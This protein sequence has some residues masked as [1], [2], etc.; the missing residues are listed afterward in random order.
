MKAP[1]S[2]IKDYVNLDGLSIEEIAR[3]LTMTGLEVDGILLVGLPKPEGEKHE[4]KYEGLSW[5]PDKFVVAR[6]DEVMPHPN[7]DKLVLCRLND[8]AKEMIILT[9]APNLFPYKAI[10]PLAEPPKVAYAR[11]GAQLY[12]GHQPCLL[13]TS[14]SPRDRG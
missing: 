2:W 4:F 11:E 7:A 9:G 12:D 14:P 5:D 8:G 6:V 10:G 1:L 3:H 13:Y